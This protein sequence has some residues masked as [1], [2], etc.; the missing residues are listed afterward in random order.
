MVSPEQR[1]QD[2]GLHLPAATKPPEGVHLPFTFVNVRGNR[3]LFSGSPKNAMDGSIAGPFGLVGKDYDTE[4]AYSEARDIGLSVLA[5]I[6][7]EIG[8]LSRIVGWTRVFGMVAS[9]PGYTEQHLVVN[10]FSD[11]IIA[12]F[13]PDIGR[14]ARSA[15]G[16]SGLP[17]GFAMEIEGEVQI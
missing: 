1:L 7:A 12:V 13:G 3:L 16:V 14:H 6:K 17:L 11:L 10:G 15:I 2:L 8:D 9:A 5:N 4:H